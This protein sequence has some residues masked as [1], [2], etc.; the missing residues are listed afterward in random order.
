MYGAVHMS[1]INQ[2]S[3]SVLRRKIPE[4]MILSAELTRAKPLWMQL[5]IR[6]RKEIHIK[7]DFMSFLLAREK[8]KYRYK[9]QSNSRPPLIVAPITEWPPLGRE[10]STKLRIIDWTCL[11]QGGH[12]TIASSMCS[13]RFIMGVEVVATSETALAPRHPAGVVPFSEMVFQM[14]IES[15][16]TFERPFAPWMAAFEMPLEDASCSGTDAQCGGI[17]RAVQE[18]GTLIMVIAGLCGKKALIGVL[19]SSRALQAAGVGVFW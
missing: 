19:C 8:M 4:F 17:Q 11:V 7:H 9:S 13:V 2:T 10:L 5:S 14:T 16:L 18:T 6:V 12:I 1:E 3:P 15:P